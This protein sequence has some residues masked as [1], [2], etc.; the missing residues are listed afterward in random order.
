MLANLASFLFT[1]TIAYFDMSKIDPFLCLFYVIIFILKIPFKL[2]LQVV[3][4]QILFKIADLTSTKLFPLTS[5][6]LST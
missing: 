4:F 3:E 6:N 1:C 5:N 2:H